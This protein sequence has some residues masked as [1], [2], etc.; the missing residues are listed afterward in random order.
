MWVWI[1]SRYL[2]AVRATGGASCSVV[3]GGPYDRYSRPMPPDL[4]PGFRHEAFL[5]RDDDEFAAGTA[6]FVQEGLEEDAAVLVALPPVG[7]AL[8]TEALGPAADRVSFLDMAEVGRNPARILA[9]WQR[10]V[11]DH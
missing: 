1:G 10:F 7:L 9:A 2:C 8:L 3:M 6:F 11:T 4:V 5:Y